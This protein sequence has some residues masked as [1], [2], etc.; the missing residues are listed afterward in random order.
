MEVFLGIP[1]NISGAMITGGEIDKFTT[2]VDSEHE[3]K[4]KLNLTATK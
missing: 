4:S 1:G 3:Q 2:D